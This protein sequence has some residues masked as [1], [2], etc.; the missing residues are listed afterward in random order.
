MS[1]NRHCEATW[2]VAGDFLTVASLH[3]LVPGTPTWGHKDARKGQT[4]RYTKGWGWLVWDLRWRSCS[5]IKEAVLTD[6]CRSS[7]VGSRLQAEIV[8]REKIPGDIFCTIV[9][10]HPQNP[11]E[12]F[13]ISLNLSWRRL[14]HSCGDEPCPR[15]QFTLTQGS[16]C[17][18]C[19][20]VWEAF[21]GWPL[22]HTRRQ[23]RGNM[24]VVTFLPLLDLSTA[25]LVFISNLD[26][27]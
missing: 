25:C 26:V 9:S 6:L 5:C 13:A 23:V 21:L 22:L 24:R 20:V 10:S 8:L 15:Q 16:S 2:T 4:H 17:C 27:L 19:C 1:I 12:G 18:S 14:H 7:S 11:K 3:D